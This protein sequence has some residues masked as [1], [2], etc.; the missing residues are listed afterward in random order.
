MYAGN[1]GNAGYQP[2]LFLGGPSQQS[3]AALTPRDRALSSTASSSAVALQQLPAAGQ[4]TIE[5]LRRRSVGR[6]D[7]LPP[8]RRRADPTAPPTA[9]LMPEFDG[10]AGSGWQAATPASTT[11]TAAQDDRF[12]TWIVAYGVDEKHKI[13]PL[14][15]L[16]AL[17][18]YGEVV[19]HQVGRG[20]WLFVRFSSKWHAEKVLAQSTFRIDN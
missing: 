11:K 14:P 18:N 20:N 9:F 6:Q 15:V 19:D 16:R 3:G 17:W 4:S 2:S 7:D 13:D 12:E 10:R 8:V 1:G 5:K